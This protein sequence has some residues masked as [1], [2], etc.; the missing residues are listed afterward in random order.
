MGQ[1]LGL[2]PV[3]HAK[4]FHPSLLVL[5]GLKV[6]RNCSEVFKAPAVGYDVTLPIM[7]RPAPH[8]PGFLT[9]FLTQFL[10]HRAEREGLRATFR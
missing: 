5:D 8:D 9:Q 1:C 2:S 7:P 4:A 10:T 6:F 3:D